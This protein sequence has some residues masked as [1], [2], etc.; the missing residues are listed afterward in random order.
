MI[1]EQTIQQ[2]ISTLSI[3]AAERELLL[4][5]CRVI[6]N[7]IERVP[8]QACRYLTV[9]SFTRYGV[10]PLAAGEA[11]TVLTELGLLVKKFAWFDGDEFQAIDVSDEF[12]AE[13]LASKEFYHPES[14]EAVTEDEWVRSF[15][16][17]WTLT[18]L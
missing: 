13:S 6:L 11:L 12:I 7:L 9:S 15:F 3:P 14:G 17:H 5:D 4:T 18:D 8:K 10:K 1:T 16:S 2:H